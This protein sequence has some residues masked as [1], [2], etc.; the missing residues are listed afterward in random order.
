ALPH[1]LVVRL[2]RATDG[3]PLFALE[4]A[5]AV[6]RAGGSAGDPAPWAVPGDLQR[7]LSAR[8]AALPSDARESL[9]AIAAMTQPTWD[10]VLAVA[11]EPARPD[12]A[13]A[14]AEQAGVIE[15]SGGRVRFSHPLLGS[16]LYVNAPPDER[17]DV[18]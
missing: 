12:L 2:H 5:R 4:I 8:L 17:R 10:I 11:N 9:L 7:L 1:P 14:V 18:H 15:R 13:L 3:I 6:V 16:T